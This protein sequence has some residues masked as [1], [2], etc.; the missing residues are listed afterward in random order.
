MSAVQSLRHG[1][2]HALKWILIISFSVLVVD[3]L[4]GVFSRYVLNAQSQWTEELAIYLL[5]WVS[6]LGAAVTYEEN[7]HLGVDYFTGKMTPDARKAA[8]VFSEVVVFCFSLFGLLIGGS[9]LVERTLDAGQMTSSLGIPKGY[10]Y[11][12]VPITG[13]FFMLFA[14]E[15][16]VL[17][18]Q[19]KDGEEAA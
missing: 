9:I 12:G 6:L 18:C 2:V 1:L 8:M 16:L 5:V 13:F 4:W 15:H 17:L 14:V 3:V 7:G 11:L 10:V 19:R